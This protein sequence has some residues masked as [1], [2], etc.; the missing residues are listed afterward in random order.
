MSA[1]SPRRP[2]LDRRPLYVIVAII[3]IVDAII[4]GAVLWRTRALTDAWENS[5]T[6]LHRLMDGGVPVVE[7]LEKYQAERGR[8]P[9]RLEELK[10]DFLSELPG[11][12]EAATQDWAYAPEAGGKGFELTLK[13]PGDF[14]PHGYGFFCTL[15]Y[16]SDR[17]Y[18]DSGYGGSKVWSDRGWA[19]YNE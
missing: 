4:V 2:K 13:L 11:K 14:Y 1:D 6:E 19:F 18:P 3:L 17:A 8:Y 7:A 9:D 5:Q 12:P 16:R 10:P 15:V